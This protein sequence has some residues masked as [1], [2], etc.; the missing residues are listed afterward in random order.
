V[1]PVEFV[2]A[3][4]AV[5]GLLSSAFT[6]AVQVAY[7]RRARTLLHEAEEAR[8]EDVLISSDLD[9]LRHY[10]YDTLGSF[11]LADFAANEKVRSRV[12]RLI[13][14]LQ[15]FAAPPE[16]PA[17]PLEELAPP[18]ETGIEPGISDPELVKAAYEIRSGEIWNGLARMRR[19]VEI[20][21][22]DLAR[23]YKPA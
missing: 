9:A 14:R 22:R 8:F 23:R 11:P 7:E 5:A 6:A 17:P 1:S 10:L 2:A 16:E 21:L 19:R 15:E 3:I 4:A 12:I 20:A 13:E 18:A